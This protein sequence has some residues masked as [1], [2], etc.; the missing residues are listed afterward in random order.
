METVKRDI[1]VVDMTEYFE[2]FGYRSRTEL[3]IQVELLPE[4]YTPAEVVHHHWL[5]FAFEAFRRL[6]EHYGVVTNRAIDT[7]C[8]I[9]TSSGLDAIGAWEALQPQ[10]MIITDIVEAVLETA[11]RNILRNCSHISEEDV[12]VL[13]GDLATPL[14][15]GNMYV[16]VA[17]ANL[18]TLPMDID[19]ETIAASGTTAASFYPRHRMAN[20][21]G[22][23]R[24]ML[25]ELYFSFLTEVAPRLSSDGLVLCAIGGR[26]PWSVIDSL[27]QGCGFDP[28]LLLF[29]LKPQEQAKEC[30]P[31]YGEFENSQVTFTFYRYDEAHQQIRDIDADHPGLTF[32]ER[33]VRHDQ[34]VKALTPFALT[35]TEA[36][37]LH[38]KG[39]TVGHLVY[40]VVGHPRDR[41]FE[42]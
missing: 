37:R 19:S 30:L 11:R 20:R 15:D 7:F 26:V 18:P 3:E 24:D 28:K 21:P 9:G 39:E 35:A 17:Y 33:L 41:G 23:A 31:V 29:D 42:E 12:V 27:F 32:T 8:D 4:M 5:Y 16:D 22:L 14:Y 13:H 25:L 40:M 36:L 34:V 1:P 6:R 2:S 38:E 10:R